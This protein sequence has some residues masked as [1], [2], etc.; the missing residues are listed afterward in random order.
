ML[1]TLLTIKRKFLRALLLAYII[2]VNP[3]IVA[4]IGMP[5]GALVTATCITAALTSILILIGL[6]T[7]TPIALAPGIGINAFFT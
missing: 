7:N 6:Y 1:L 2:A 4:N 3:A 5:I